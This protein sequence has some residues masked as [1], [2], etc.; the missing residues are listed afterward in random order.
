MK[1]HLEIT[2]PDY[3]NFYTLY[4]E[5]IHSFKTYD[6]VN[7]QTLIYYAP[8]SVI[9]LY[10]TYI[11][12]REAVVVRFEQDDN[13]MTALPGLDKKVTLLFRVK[14]SKVDKLKRVVAWLNNHAN[15]AY[16]HSDGFYLRLSFLLAQRGAKPDYP[17]LSK[18]VETAPAQKN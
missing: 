4:S 17:A 16:T 9:V 2:I 12:F 8:G 11:T 18:L 7:N 13:K 14:A 5:G 15:G 1:S 10:Y 3:N 6:K